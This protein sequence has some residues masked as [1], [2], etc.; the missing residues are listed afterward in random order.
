MTHYLVITEPEPGV[1]EYEIEHD[2][3]CPSEERDFGGT[4]E[5]KHEPMTYRDHTCL[6]GLLVSE[7]GIDDAVAD[8]AEVPVGRHEVRGVTEHTPSLPTN[9]GEEWDAWIEVVA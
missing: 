2:S 6:V 8:I 7:I 5:E 4:F 3:S 9:G 1:R